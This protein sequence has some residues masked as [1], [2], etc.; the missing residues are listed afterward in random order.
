[1]RFRSA[2]FLAFIC[3]CLLA[4]QISGLHLHANPQGS[5]EL[6][7]SHV[8]D[9]DSDGHDHRADTDIGYL[10]YSSGWVKPLPFL[11]LTFAVFFL[12]VNYCRR[13]WAP[14]YSNFLHRSYLRWRPPLRAPPP[15]VS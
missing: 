10:E 14:V 9:A 11:F 1:M 6:H 5:G 7:G 13:I 3:L 4:L 8:H 12:V 15:L 2:K